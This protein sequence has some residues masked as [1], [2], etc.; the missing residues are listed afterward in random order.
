[1]ANGVASYTRNGLKAGRE[2]EFT[3]QARD[4]VGNLGPSRTV[5][6]TV[7]HP[8]EVYF[9]GIDFFPLGDGASESMG[10][11]AAGYYFLY[12]LAEGFIRDL[13][14]AT[15]HWTEDSPETFTFEE[16]QTEW[17]VTW[18]YRPASLNPAFFFPARWCWEVSAPGE[19][20]K[21][22]ITSESLEGEAVW[23]FDYYLD[24]PD[25]SP[26]FSASF[27]RDAILGT[28]R[29]VT[30]GDH[31]DLFWRYLT[32]GA[33]RYEARIE[34]YQNDS[35][36]EYILFNISQDGNDGD[37]ALTDGEQTISGSW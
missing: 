3:V 6:A 17:T 36:D 28:A 2:Y 19:D 13:D 11:D 31:I 27:F 5:T 7:F 18:S 21:V 30:S 10:P 32:D 25:T 16:G 1:M 23:A 12:S 14:R 9:P 4:Q 37:W 20:Y 26:F 15:E 24:P 29:F 34:T 35:V 8:R 33:N 22:C